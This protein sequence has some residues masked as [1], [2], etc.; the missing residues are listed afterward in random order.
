MGSN[1]SASTSPATTATASV[2]TNESARLPRG[3]GGASDRLHRLLRLIMQI[4]SQQ[5]NT[6]GELAGALGVSRRTV[7]RDLKVLQEAGVP[8]VNIPQKGYQ[9]DPDFDAAFQKLEPGEMLGMMLLSKVAEALPDLPLLRPAHAGVSK[10]AAQLPATVRGFYRELLSTVT[11]APGVA[12]I[13][14][15][16]EDRFCQFQRAIEERA[17][18]NVEYRSVPPHEPFAGALHPLHLHFYKHSWF[19]LA[20][21]EVHDEVRMF[22]LSRFQRVHLDDRCFAPMPF[23]IHEYLDDAWGVIP[24][25]RKYDITIRFTPRVARNV[26]ELNWHH[27]QQIEFDAGGSC[28]MRVRVNGLDEI[29]W[30]IIGYGDQAEVLEPAELREKIAE[31]ARS[32]LVQYDGSA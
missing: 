27:S 14:P 1:T 21:S 12:R 6:A 20:F 29:K 10:I 24:G 18:C 2:H 23:D 16:V 31:M 30:W 7:F 32:L 26:A 5:R 19:L 15:A 9:L 22:N 8:L 11:F 13:D 25:G 17:V 4:Q 3:G 28:I